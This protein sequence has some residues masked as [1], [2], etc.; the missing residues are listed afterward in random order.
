MINGKVIAN[1]GNLI[2]GGA[3]QA[4]VN[5]IQVNLTLPAPKIDWF[6]IVHQ[7]LL[8][9][10]EGLNIQ[11]PAEQL[12]VLSDSPATNKHARSLAL[13]FERSIQPDLVFTLFGPSY[14][15]FKSFHLTGFA[16]GWVTHG[17]L[18]TL[19]QTY[20]HKP[21][22]QLKSLFKYL[23]YAWHIRQADA[24]VLETQTALNGFIQRL[25]VPAK[26]CHVVANTCIDFGVNFAKQPKVSINNIP[27]Q[28][29]NKLF[30]ALAADYPHKN[31]VQ[32]IYAAEHLKKQFNQSNFKLVL[33]M[34]KETFQQQYKPLISR[35]NVTNQ[36]INLGKVQIADIVKLYSV[37]FC[38]VLPSF[39]ETFSAV[40]PESFASKTPVITTNADFAREVCQGAALYIQP[41]KSE[42]IAEKM[43]LLLTNNDQYQQLVTA[44]S[45][46]YHQML[47]P[48]QKHQQTI[49]IIQRYLLKPDLSSEANQ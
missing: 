40:Y 19:K 45:N 16:N 39:I 46:I 47:T 8:S 28:Y 33:T 24:W 11:I 27:L 31:L 34:P 49:D 3:L 22:H 14:L 20:P 10:L 44:G 48:Q 37:A 17:S 30:I 38:S 18:K 4:A 5:F 9:E 7:E 13:A 15:N 12:L 21:L 36:V 43:N 26:R 6:Y 23:Y 35:L 42:D 1:F 41:E 29:Q 2:K 32:L 25:K